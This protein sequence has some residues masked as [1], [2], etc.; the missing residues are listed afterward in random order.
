MESLHNDLNDYYQMVMDAEQGKRDN[1][2]GYVGDG[3]GTGT[4]PEDDDTN[5]DDYPEDRKRPIGFNPIKT[6]C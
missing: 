6:K 2:M 5:G 1:V 4:G 3:I